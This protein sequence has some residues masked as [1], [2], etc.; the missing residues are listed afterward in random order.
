MSEPGSQTAGAKI[1]QIRL[2]R[3][4]SQ[5]KLA[6]RAGIS[7]RTIQSIE[8]GSHPREETAIAIAD[9]LAVSIEDIAPEVAA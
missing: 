8:A 6:R 5:E 7:T 1:R 2:A 3:F 9:A 4:W